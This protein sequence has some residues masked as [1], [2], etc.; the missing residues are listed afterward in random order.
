MRSSTLLILL[1]S[2]VLAYTTAQDS[3]TRRLWQIASGT[4]YCSYQCDIFSEKC[5][6]PAKCVDRN[7]LQRVQVNCFKRGMQLYSSGGKVW[8][9]EER[10]PNW[11]KE[12]GHPLVFR[13]LNS[14]IRR[15]T[16]ARKNEAKF[17][18]LAEDVAPRRMLRSF[19]EG[20]ERRRLLITCGT[21]SFNCGLGFSMGTQSYCKC[22]CREKYARC[23]AR[24]HTCGSIYRIPE[25]VCSRSRCI[26]D[27]KGYYPR[28]G[29]D[30]LIECLNERE[31]CNRK[32]T[33]YA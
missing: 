5:P 21:P 25:K 11:Y 28:E 12:I 33:R 20:I 27:W 2:F 19:V 3:F 14:F 17:L 4:H 1:P 32:C 22:D 7:W 8:C 24:M 13:R 23:L 18:H 6:Y 29:A 26:W 16:R 10:N 9:D 15:L 31:Q 30:D